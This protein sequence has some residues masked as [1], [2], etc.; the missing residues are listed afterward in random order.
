MAA[1]VVFDTRQFTG[2]DAVFGR[3]AALIHE[4]SGIV[5]S[6]AKRTMVE[7][8]LVRR[9]EAHGVDDLDQ[10]VDKLFTERRIEAELPLLLDALS[11]NTT[12]FFREPRQ[13]KALR[14][15]WL[16]A[17]LES[18]GTRQLRTWSAASSTGPEVYTLAMVLS[19][20][21]ARAGGYRFVCLGTDISREAIVE[22]RAGTYP[23]RMLGPI[24]PPYRNK[25]WLACGRQGRVT[26]FRARPFLRRHTRFGTMNL[27]ARRYSVPSGLD[28]IFLRNVLFYFD[29]HTQRKV[30]GH[31]RRHLRPGGLLVL[32]MSEP[33]VPEGLGLARVAPSVYRAE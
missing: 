18:N 5:L 25:Y 16:D 19:E 24:P 29:G 2:A 26:H 21:Q 7:A 31:L 33:L 9:F 17:L 23:I 10:Y 1:P 4:K 32:G 12:S 3:L 20:H 27:M 8:R 6:A 15:E 14:E 28:L 22:A 11:M 13:F 30:I